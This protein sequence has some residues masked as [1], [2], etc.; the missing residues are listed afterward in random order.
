MHPTQNVILILSNLL[1]I[2]NRKI[3]IL[4]LSN[5]LSISIRVM[6]SIATIL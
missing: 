4:V 1:Y 2:S 6:R 3:K 5:V